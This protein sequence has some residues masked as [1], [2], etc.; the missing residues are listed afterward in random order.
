MLAGG[1]PGVEQGPQ[2]GAL[3]ARVPLPELVAQ[4]DHALLGPGLLLI[5]AAAAEDA[6]EAAL[7]DRVEQRAGLQRVAGAVGALPQAA[8]VDVVL[9]GGDDEPGAGRLRRGV[10]VVQD[11]GEVVPGVHVEEGEGHGCRPEG[12]ARQVEHDDRVLPAAEQQDGAGALG[13]RLT[14]DE[15]RLGLQRVE[16][17]ERGAGGGDRGGGRVGDG[18]GAHRWMPHS[19]LA[20]P[21]QRPERGS[22]PGATR[23]VQGSQPIEG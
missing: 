19:V 13:G 12:L 10:P 9:D 17:V 2:L 16:L 15:D 21:A 11:L 7:G 4:G 8:V 23:A 6:V 1:V 18:G 3:V 5:A 20:N 22:C 14:D